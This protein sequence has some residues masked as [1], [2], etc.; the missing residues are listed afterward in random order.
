MLDYAPL[1]S[2]NF[3]L[4]CWLN[5]FGE[6]AVDKIVKIFIV[7]HFYPD[8]CLFRFSVLPLASFE[9]SYANHVE[10]PYLNIQLCS[11]ILEVTVHF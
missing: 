1:C 9:S 6:K 5:Y 10:F 11:V 7:I 4:V 3:L 8:L 2:F